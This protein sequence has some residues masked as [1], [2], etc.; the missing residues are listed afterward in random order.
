MEFGDVVGLQI[1]KPRTHLEDLGKAYLLCLVHG[2]FICEMD[3]IIPSLHML[4]T[5]AYVED[6]SLSK[7]QCYTNMSLFS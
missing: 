1:R 6:K 4:M 3:L 5:C 2:V 7:M